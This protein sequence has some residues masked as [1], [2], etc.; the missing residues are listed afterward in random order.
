MPWLVQHGP[1]SL[2]FILKK[3]ENMKITQENLKL[4]DRIDKVKSSVRKEEMLRHQETTDLHKK[5]LL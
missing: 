2:N 1:K 4:K 3:H 5:M